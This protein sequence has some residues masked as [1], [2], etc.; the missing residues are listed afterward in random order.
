MSGARRGDMVRC[1][2]QRN[3]HTALAVYGTGTAHHPL[4]RHTCAASPHS[5][6]KA[7]STKMSV[8]CS[9]PLWL[10]VQ[11]PVTVRAGEA[12]RRD[13]GRQHHRGAAAEGA[14]A[15]KLRH[16]VDTDGAAAR[17]GPSATDGG[18]HRTG[19]STLC[20]SVRLSTA[21]LRLHQ[22]SGTFLSLLPPLW[23]C[24]SRWSCITWSFEPTAY[25]GCGVQATGRLALKEPYFRQ[26]NSPMPEQP[27]ADPVGLVQ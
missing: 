16:T 22:S 8:P 11:V 4:V 5:T 26:L 23:R 9:S 18:C 15:A 6:G 21:H 10:H 25:S 2:L 27:T 19:A 13:G 17:S 14:P 20:T 12:N 3:H 7:R 1:A 24:E